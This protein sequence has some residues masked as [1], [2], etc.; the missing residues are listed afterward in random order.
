MSDRM[1]Y[2]GMMTVWVILTCSTGGPAVA[3]FWPFNQPNPQPPRP[4]PAE[5]YRPGQLAPIQPGDPRLTP[6][7][8]GQ[9][10]IPGDIVA[11]GQPSG[12][13]PARAQSVR[14][15]GEDAV[16]GR[17]LR[18]NGSSGSLRIERTGASYGARL[19]IEGSRVSRPTDA[20]QV[21]L[22]AGEPVATTS[23]GRPAGLLRYR[24]EAPACPIAFDI[25]DGA[26]LVTEPADGCVFQE[27][28][29]K[30]EIKG[31]WGPE[32]ASI[33][34]QSRAIEQARGRADQ[35]VRENYKAL[36]QKLSGLEARAVIAEQA[37]FSAERTVMCRDY[38]RESAHGFCHARFSEA[39]AAT[40]AAKLGLA[41]ATD[42]PRPARP[43]SAQPAPAPLQ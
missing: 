31:V 18:R 3:Q 14:T 4:V 10:P 11:P 21:E 38:A 32:P 19:T 43:R 8:P 1:K 6:P 15:A 36:N 42:A 33:M 25:L 2:A 41:P 35:I 17:A 26:V 28:D 39:R 40:L 20:C 13:P 9:P 30:V 24:I 37:G 16:V 29:C 7:A 34:S 22:G 23:L 27:A 5:P 12:P